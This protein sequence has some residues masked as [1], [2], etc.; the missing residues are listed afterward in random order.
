MIRTL[1]GLAAL[2]IVGWTA[3]VA[4]DIWRDWRWRRRGRP[5][6][7]CGRLHRPSCP[8]AVAAL[9]GATRQH[10]PFENLT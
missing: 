6:C 1:I 4:P 8:C 2:A 5:M 3:P 10:T 9:P 7:A